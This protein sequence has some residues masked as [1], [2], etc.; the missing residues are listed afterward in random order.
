[1][2]TAPTLLL[3]AALVGRVSCKRVL[4]DIP[5]VGLGPTRSPGTSTS[6][7][8]EEE[9]F[10]LEEEEGVLIE[11]LEVDDQVTGEDK[12]FRT[13]Y[14]R[15]AGQAH[16]NFFVCRLPNQATAIFRIHGAK[17]SFFLSYCF[18]YLN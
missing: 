14:V 5:E 6:L 12:H 2:K 8:E 10:T 3:A 15:R 13:A 18:M 17:P 7:A 11:A 16:S 4:Q 1:M 9:S